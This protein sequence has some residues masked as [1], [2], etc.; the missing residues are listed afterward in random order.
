M[1]CSL[2]PLGL[3]ASHK[4]IGDG[5]IC[6]PARNAA[7]VVFLGKTAEAAA[8]GLIAAVL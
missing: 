4:A 2:Q 1:I 7:R 3:R 8:L 6:R 5:T